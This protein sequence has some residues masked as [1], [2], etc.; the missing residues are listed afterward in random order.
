MIKEVALINT[1]AWYKLRTRRSAFTFIETLAV[2]VYIYAK[3]HL[4]IE[5]KPEKENSSLET[6][7]GF[8]YNLV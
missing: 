5:G 7:C 8:D 1:F 6:I 4:I 3:Y 2:E